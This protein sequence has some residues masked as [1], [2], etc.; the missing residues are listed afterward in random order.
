MADNSILPKAQ[1]QLV[2]AGGRP[3][4][5][6]YAFFN[7]LVSR[8][9]GQI[10][11]INTLVSKLAA[12]IKALGGDVDDMPDIPALIDGKADKTI[13]VLG[14]GSIAGGG[15]LFGDVYLRLDG[16]TEDDPAPLSFYGVLGDTPLE[17]SSGRGWQN[18]ADNFAARDNGDG[19]LSLDLADLADSGTGAALVKLTRDAKGRISGTEAA[20]TTDL[21]E[22]DNLYFTDARAAAAAP[23]QSLV[24]GANVTIDATDPR[25]P[26]V[27][28]TGGGGGGGG[29]VF[30]PSSATNNAVALFSGT[31]GK[32][33]KNGVVLGS[34]ATTAASD[35][36]TAAQ[37][38]KADTALQDAS[39]FATAAQ[40]AAADTAV[41]PGALAAVA[42]SGSYADLADKPSIPA[43]QVNADWDAVS[44]VAEVLNK[45]TLG[46]ASAQDVGAFATA[47]QGALAEAA[48][49]SIVAGSG[50]TV[51]AT[52]PRHPVVNAT[53]GGT[54]AVDSVNGQTGVVVLDA[55]DV[56]AATTAQ[57]ATADTAIQAVVAGANVTVDN[58]N[59][60]RPVVSATGSGGI[61][62]HF[63][64]FLADGTASN[65]ALTADQK[66]P[67]FLA[68]G[69]RADV[70]LIT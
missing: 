45:P 25:N 34:A 32:L 5:A 2:D 27:S 13:N 26:I 29:D 36:A 35:Y 20:T 52:D 63:P 65:I 57:G 6:F 12:V 11:T 9:Q 7:A 51:D 1:S 40:G 58:T 19:T 18:F 55:A 23:I 50:V 17:P 48:V 22:G 39:A 66:L 21:A 44:G 46:T 28:S 68:D 62:V 33:L 41:Q 67:F 43:A 59:P 37:G 56:G 4:R 14:T 10:D 16:D 3:T 30:G 15:N 54:G 64:F 8:F 70:A 42:T 61:T 38:A 49:Q 47:T 31:T 53:G 60:L 24:A 69:T